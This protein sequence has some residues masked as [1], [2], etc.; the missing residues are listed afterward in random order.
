M[1]QGT[2]DDICFCFFLPSAF[3]RHL[4][5]LFPRGEGK[6]RRPQSRADRRAACVSVCVCLCD[7]GRR[8]PRPSSRPPVE[9]PLRPP[10]TQFLQRE[11]SDLSFVF[12]ASFSVLGKSNVASHSARNSTCALSEEFG[13][14][15]KK[16]HGNRSGMI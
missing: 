13:K 3:L 1:R 15:K 2:N 8:H 10:L 16:F 7:H 6:R 5:C 9:I 4:I 12:F 11:S 14:R